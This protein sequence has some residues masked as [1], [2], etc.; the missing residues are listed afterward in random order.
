MG[1]S[2]DLKVEFLVD[3]GQVTLRGDGQQL[4]SERREDAV[5]AGGV[6]AQRVLEFLSAAR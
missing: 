6:I 2:E 5:V 3:R 4:G 1:L